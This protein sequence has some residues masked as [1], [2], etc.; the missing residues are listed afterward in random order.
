MLVV[1]EP[2]GPVAH[3][4]IG[5][6]EKTLDSFQDRIE[7]FLKKETIINK[8]LFNQMI[9]LELRTTLDRTKNNFKF[10]EIFSHQTME[11]FLPLLLHLRGQQMSTFDHIISDLTLGNQCHV[12]EKHKVACRESSGH[13]TEFRGNGTLRIKTKASVFEFKK[14]S[15]P[16]CLYV[17]DPQIKS[18]ARFMGNELAFLKADKGEAS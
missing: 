13:I 16:Q 18:G 15:L 9:D 10:F 12:S 14:I 8:S 5:A 7:I 3:H 2:Q 11:K 17:V 6:D 1:R 4:G